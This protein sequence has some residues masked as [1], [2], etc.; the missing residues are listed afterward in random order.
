MATIIETDFLT[1]REA[2]AALGVPQSTVRRWI[3]RGDLPAYRVGQRRLAVR[4][5]DLNRLLPAARTES[6][7]DIPAA[8]VEHPEIAPPTPE[9]QARGLAAIEELKRINEELLAERGGKPF[10]P[11]WKIINELRD[12]RSR[13]LS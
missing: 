4:R 5:G 7:T 13:Q 10:S 11:S 9:E 1:V 3:A 8:P 6:G 12:E 2:A